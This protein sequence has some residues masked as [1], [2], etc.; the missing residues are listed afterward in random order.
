MKKHVAAVGDVEFDVVADLA[1]LAAIGNELLV[2]LFA[3]MKQLQKA[4]VDLLRLRDFPFSSR[5]PLL[6]APP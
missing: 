6:D 3:F 2:A 4:L 1:G 5:W